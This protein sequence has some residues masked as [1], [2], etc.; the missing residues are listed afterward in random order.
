MGTLPR[1]TLVLAD[2]PYGN[3]VWFAGLGAQGCWGLVRRNQWLGLR[4]IRCLARRA[5]EGGRHTDWLVEAGGSRATPPQRLRYIRWQRGATVRA[6]LT[7]VLDPARLLAP[8]GARPLPPPLR[9]CPPRPSRRPGS[10]RS[11]RRPPIATP[12]SRCGSSTPSARTAAG[13]FA[14]PRCSSL[15]SP[16]S[17]WAQL[18]S[19]RGQVGGG[20]AASVRRG[21]TGNRCRMCVVVIKILELP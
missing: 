13:G 2:R 19:K 5:L 7:N 18:S 14:R 15:G 21:N 10:S 17:R 16:T 12:S 11:W 20:N 3:G 6:V 8:R 9:G 1:D 4:K